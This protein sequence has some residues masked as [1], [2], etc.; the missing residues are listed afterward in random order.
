MIH[1]PTLELSR[2]TDIVGFVVFPLYLIVLAI[3]LYNHELWGDEI[4]SWNIA[5][6]SGSLAE[7]FL[8]MRYEGHPPVLYILMWTISKFTLNVYWIQVLHFVIAGSAISLLLLK[9]PLPQPV[10]YLLPFGY[11]FLYEYATLSRNYSIGIFLACCIC[12]VMQKDKIRNPLYYFLLFALSN[13]HLLGL[14]LAASIHLYFL[15]RKVAQNGKWKAAIHLLAGM[16]VLA[17]AFYFIFPPTDSEL[18]LDFWLNRWNDT[19][20][21][22]LSIAPVKAFL[23]LPPPDNPNFWNLHYLTDNIPLTGSR[24][25]SVVLVALACF[26]LRKSRKSLF[27]FLFNLLLTCIVA[28][29]F[30]MMSARYTGFIFIGFVISCWLH[31][32]EF[33]FSRTERRALTFLFIAQMAGSLV[34]VPADIRRTFSHASK[35]KDITDKLPPGETVATDY[36]CLNNLSAFTAKP[37]YCVGLNEEVSFIKWDEAFAKATSVPHIYTD[38]FDLLFAKTHAGYLMLLSSNA[39]DFIAWRDTLVNSR[40][41]IELKES[42]TGA[43]EKGSNVYVYQVR[44]K[45]GE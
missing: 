1:A 38:G 24:I 9:S 34:A 8:N 45:T 20:I 16:V 42:F 27:V 43:I 10:K 30:P 17:P 36:W 6:G 26:I 2:K 13:T 11:F 5:K 3:S 44:Q 12:L 21:E 39:P 23:P 28:I 41:K 25:V 33:P 37:Y 7:L 15:L 31:C 18:N 22:A 32:I 19:N 29:L 4:H 14:L 35:V 40:Y